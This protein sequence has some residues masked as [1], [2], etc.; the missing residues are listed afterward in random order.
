MY[1]SSCLTHSIATFLSL[2]RWRAVCVVPGVDLSHQL[3][4]DSRAVQGESPTKRNGTLYTETTQRS[5]KS[6]KA[7]PRQLARGVDGIRYSHAVKTG[8]EANEN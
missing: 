1:Q 2:S 5:M 8:N 6:I 7:L 3:S 4:L